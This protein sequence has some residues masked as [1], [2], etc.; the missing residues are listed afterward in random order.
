[1]LMSGVAGSV[2]EDISGVDDLNEQLSG[3]LHVCLTSHSKTRQK[4]GY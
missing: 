1:M 4:A 3:D 2:T